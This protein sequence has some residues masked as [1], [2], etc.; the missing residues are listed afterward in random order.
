MQLISEGVRESEGDFI[1]SQQMNGNR[2]ELFKKSTPEG[3]CKAR[4]NH[5]TEYAGRLIEVRS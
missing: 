3:L 5:L 1:A 2:G 4:L